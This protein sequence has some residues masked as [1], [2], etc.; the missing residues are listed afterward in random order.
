MHAL[1]P[2]LSLTFR[3]VDAADKELG[4]SRDLDELQRRLAGRARAP[5]SAASRTSPGMSIDGTKLAEFP[6]ELPRSV[7]VE[8]GGRRMQAYP[9]L[10]DRESHVDLQ[11][12]ESAAAA[13]AATREGVRRLAIFALRHVV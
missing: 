6:A 8:V 3:V 12:M 4:K 9:A 2:Y 10:V 1:P 5:W 11:L 13:D 7:T